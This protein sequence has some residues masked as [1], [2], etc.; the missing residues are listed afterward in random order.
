MAQTLKVGMEPDKI[1]QSVTAKNWING[2]WN[3]SDKH[4]DC[5]DP[6]TGTKIEVYADA[7]LADVQNGVAAAVDA[8]QSTDWK[9]NRKLRAK[10]L[11]QI[12]DRFEARRKDLIQILPLESGKVRGEAA[13][14]VD[15]IP[16]KF[17][18]WASVAL[19]D[20]GRAMEMLRGRKENEP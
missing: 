10:V 9:D 4:T 7:S 6:A 3:D 20:Y 13:F 11:N 17:R 18:F 1:A 8:F 19:T 2:E 5:F 14:E 15:M 12:A 16:S